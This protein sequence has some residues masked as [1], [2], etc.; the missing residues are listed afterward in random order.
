[1][2]RSG[3]W[4]IVTVLMTLSLPAWGGDG[5]SMSPGKYKD[6]ERFIDEL[7]IIQP[8]KLSAYSQVI[9]FPLET[10][11]TPLPEKDDNTFEPTTK[12]L[13]KISQI[14]IE[15]I[16]KGVQAKIPVVLGE[17]EPPSE[18]AESGIL[19]VRG[20]VT[21]MNPGSRAARFW[22]GFGAGRSRVEIQGIVL[23]AKTQKELL[24]FK[25][26]RVSALGVFGGDYEN[27]LTGDARNVGEDIGKLLLKF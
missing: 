22:V 15:G 24:R 6:W 17:K 26:A 11:S 12:T 2:K 9:I 7:E 10:S 20:R 5:S 13:S 14:F 16:T 19:V 1:M 8:F 27:F 4:F 23:D 3:F 21:E 18:M 25:H